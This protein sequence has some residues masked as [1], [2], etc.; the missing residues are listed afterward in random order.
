MSAIKTLLKRLKGKIPANQIYV[1]EIDRLAKGTDAGFYR[2]I[3]QLVIQVN[4]EE[5][6][7]AVLQS[8]QLLNI[9]C[10]F[11]AAGT[12]L[13]G[14]TITDSV[15]IEIGPDFNQMSIKDN[16]E[17]ATFQPGI[18]G[19][20]ANQKLAK[21]G[22]KIGSSP[23]SLNAA[24][25]G[26]I[27]ANNASGAS[28]G[29]IT[30]SYNTLEN[31]RIVLADGAVLDTSENDSRN[32]F[33]ISHK[34]LLDKIEEIKERI[35]TNEHIF[36]KIK[37]KY[38]LKNTTGY[39]MN[40]FIDFDD[41]IDIMAHL[42][43]GSEGTLGFISNVTLKTI[44]DYPNKTCALLFLPNIGEAAKAILPLRECKVSAAELMD[45][46]ALRAVEDVDGMPSILKELP[47][48]AAA[49]LIET[50]AISFEELETQQS[51]I[52]EKLKDVSTLFPIR[53][54]DNFKDYATYWKVRKG[55]FT[56]AAATRSIGS[57]CIIEDIA[58]PGETLAQALSDLQNLLKEHN[59]KGSVTW[60]HLLDGNIH[61]LIMP[62]FSKI[63]EME[64]YKSF[65]N[66]LADLVIKKYNGSLKA[67]HGTGRNMAPFVEFEWGTDIFQLMKEVKT[68]FDPKNILNP[69]VLI[70]DDPEV[71]TKN[72]KPLPQANEIIDKCIECGFCEHSCPSRDL[73]LTPRQRITVFRQWNQLKEAGKAKEVRKLAKEYRYRGEESC[74]TDGLCALNCPVNINTGSLIKQLRFAQ[75]GKL[76]LSIASF[77][78][79]RFGKFVNIARVVLNV[80]HWT[81]RMIPELVIRQI[82][83][84]MHKGSGRTIPLW[85]KYMPKGAPEIKPQISKIKSQT[86]DASK[87]V[88]FPACI[89]RIFGNS[90]EYREKEALTQV[91]R[92]LLEKAGYEIIYPKNLQNQCCGM[93]FDSK[94]FKK[95]GEQKLKELEAALLEASENGKLPVLCDMSPCLLRMKDLMDKR[96]ELMEP[97]EFSLKYLKKNL[98]FNKLE[99]TVMVHATC[100]TTKMGLEDKLVELAEMCATKVIKPEK[101]G[102]CGWAG[103]KGFNLPE[104]NKSA[105]RY[106]KEETPEKVNY[107]Y[108]NSRTCEIGLSLHSG[109]SY[110]SILYLVDKST[111]A[112]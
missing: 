7:V 29:I 73:T 63:E 87:V 110:K 42:M 37:A 104:L 49:L 28:Y 9:P 82:A 101:T 90:M 34:E 14:Q 89:N 2:L 50:S 3:P 8:C 98:E 61:F 19:G 108:S 96:L 74:A 57:S 25:I 10:T 24:K 62:D 77:I 51:E 36:N 45:R 105:L 59:Y 41:P 102:C 35:V 39:G 111:K 85:N 26:G 71:H 64:S 72:I 75:K 92:I 53:F 66:K 78:A 70:N 58:F 56:S 18:R 97:I 44:E 15:L 6:I 31:I 5:E 11:K 38:K 23:A 1:K 94:G 68:A 83:N 46:N 16:G 67:E 13:S 99:E 100:S 17:T 65:M 43:V 20:F 69:G 60:G 30:N 52:I 103:D 81:Q 27:V 55:L 76:G 22:R 54:T 84:L 48:A 93:A 12:S 88:Y 91:T 107:G 79:K 109:I 106:L 95:Q 86:I 32:S 112:L 4:N 33:K 80:V 47:D 40:S 21:Y